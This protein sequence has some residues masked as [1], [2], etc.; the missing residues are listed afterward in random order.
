M[1]IGI[2]AELSPRKFPEGFEGLEGMEVSAVTVGEEHAVIMC[3]EVGVRITDEGQDCCES[4]YITTDDDPARLIG[5]RLASI[6]S[7]EVKEADGM[8]D[9]CHDIVFVTIRTDTAELV[10]QSHNCL[11]YTSPSPRDS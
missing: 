11:L 4:R 5:S 9:E 8:D 1:K 3:G 2:T 6:T 10:L 7:G